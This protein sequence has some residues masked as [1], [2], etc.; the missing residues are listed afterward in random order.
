M[1]LQCIDDISVPWLNQTLNTESITDFS[2]QRV[3]EGVG[4]MGILALVQIE[5][6]DNAVPKS[7]VVKIQTDDEQNLIVADTYDS[8][9][10]EIDFYRILADDCGL[11]TAICYQAEI[12]E[13][14]NQFV[15]TLQDLSKHQVVDQIEGSNAKQTLLAVTKLASLHA[16]YWDSVESGPCAEMYNFDD[17]LASVVESYPVMLE[18]SL[19]I[20]KT[21][22]PEDT[23]NF[24][25]SFCQQ[26][27]LL[28]TK[29][30]S[31]NTFIHGDYRLDNFFYSGDYS[32]LVVI[33]WGNSAKGP[34]MFDLSYFLSTSVPTELRRTI[35]KDAIQLYC[36]TLKAS[37]VDYDFESCWQDYV[38]G[39]PLAFFIPIIVLSSM[40]AGNARGDLLAQTIYDRG[41]AAMADHQ[42]HLSGLI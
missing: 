11:N 37:G 5:S 9:G 39:V 20:S 10:R 18:G 19:E 27:P 15:L 25:R 14:R 30:N 32:D 22:V 26:L 33:D 12:N 36:D 34:P 41:I 13:K 28:Q 16:R 4:L 35:E 2:T 31:H 24:L 40:G 6:T 17:L 7:V 38:W 29:L 42:T 1:L 8:Y 23:A 21:P 3:G